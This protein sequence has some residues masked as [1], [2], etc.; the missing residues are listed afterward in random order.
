MEQGSQNPDLEQRLVAL[1]R[2]IARAIVNAD[3]DKIKKLTDEPEVILN[4]FAG[5]L[6]D[7][8][9]TKSSILRP[10][11]DGRKIMIEALD[12]EAQ[13]SDAKNI[14][15]A[16]IHENFKNWGLDQPGPATAETLCDVS[17]IT[18][19]ATAA[20]IFTSITS[21][22]D[23][24]VMTQAQIIR[25]CE[26]YPTWFD[27]EGSATLFLTKVNGEYFMV[28]VSKYVGCVVDASD[29]SASS[30]G[31]GV[32]VYSLDDIGAW[33]GDRRHRVVYPRFIPLAA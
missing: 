3:S 25:F 16:F 33:G 26:K 30:D 23:R 29:L 28:D 10:I 6:S 22:L 12:G 7:N 2:I 19:S 18:S 9:E 21:N 13:I 4:F 31:L 24:L 20:Q 5:L 11:S 32:N 1:A 8:A 15:K 14:F 17:E 27:R